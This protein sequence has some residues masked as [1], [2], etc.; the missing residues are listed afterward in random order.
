M[1]GRRLAVLLFAGL[2]LLTFSLALAAPPKAAGPKKKTG[3][4][5]ADGKTEAGD[6]KADAAEKNSAAADDDEDSEPKKVVKTDA[7]WMKML[8][9][10]QFRA[11]RK[12]RTERPF[13]R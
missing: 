7:E 12:K 8:T 4:A 1:P 3:D 11:A 13:S 5:A 9:R 6:A 10:E 2:A